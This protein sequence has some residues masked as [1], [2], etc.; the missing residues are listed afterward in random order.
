M[1]KSNVLLGIFA[2]AALGFSSCSSDDDG[3]SG[4]LAGTYELDQVNIGT[5]IDFDQDGDTNTDLTKE[6]GCYDS[7]K[8]TLNSDGTLTF[9]KSYVLV[10]EDLGTSTCASNTFTGTW[11]IQ[12]QTGSTVVVEA[13]YV[14]ANDDEIMVQLTKQG[15]KLR[16]TDV[17]GQYPNRNGEGGAIYSTGSVEYVFDK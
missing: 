10:D 4:T 11:L 2:L 7:G 5:A 15:D 13:T 16:Y 17:F 14:D 6:S 1:K 3:N 9:V 12:G 8:I